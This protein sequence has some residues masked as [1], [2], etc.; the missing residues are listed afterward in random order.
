LIL[1]VLTALSAPAWSKIKMSM[2]PSDVVVE[3]TAK[4]FNW[5]VKYPNSDQVI[6]DEMHV[7]VN[8]VVHVHLKSQ[9][10]VDG[11]VH[12][13]EEDLVRV[14]VFHLPVELHEMHVPVNKVV[15]VH[16]KSQDVIHS[17]FVPQFRM[18]QDAVPG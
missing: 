9:D 17:F 1:V 15:H 3:V 6:L 11:D 10:V 18:K 16:L 8:K 12:L 5:Q 2:P 13:V 14:R 4:Q 7:P